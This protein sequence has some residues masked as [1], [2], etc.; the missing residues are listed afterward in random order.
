[1]DSGHLL[2]SFR[3]RHEQDVVAARQRAA[4][5]AALAGFDTSDQT[6]IATGV[7]EIVRN[8]FRYAGGGVVEYSLE[9]QTIPQVLLVKVSDSGRGIPNL[10]DVLEGR[11]R[12]TTGMGIGLAGTRRLMDHFEISSSTT[13]TVV[14]LKKLLPRRAPFISPAKA[15]EIARDI[16]EHHPGG[17]VEEIQRQ[18]QEL[19]RALDELQRRQ[20]ELVR[21]NR[22]LE[23]TNRGVVALYAELD[24]KADHLRRADELKSRFLSNMTHE[25]RTPVNSILALTDLLDQ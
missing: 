1:M 14:S 20:D 5:I 22:E 24:E 2:L 18:N 11:Y 23:D 17:L 19:L 15:A 4:Q 3:V 25:F 16:H 10:D 12:S 6:R 7:S 21:L 13:G 9:G 8:A